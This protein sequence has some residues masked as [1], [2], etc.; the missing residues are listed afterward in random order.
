MAN[1]TSHILITFN[2][3]LYRT[4]FSLPTFSSLISHFQCIISATYIFSL[5]QTD[6]VKATWLLGY[7]NIFFLLCYSYPTIM[8]RE[9]IKLCNNTFI[10]V[11][12]HFIIVKKKKWIQH[13]H[14]FSPLIVQF[15]GFFSL[16]LT[17]LPDFNEQ[18]S[19]PHFSADCKILGKITSHFH[20]SLAGFIWSVAMC[21]NFAR[22]RFTDMGL[23]Q[24]YKDILNWNLVFVAIKIEINVW[25][26]FEY[27]IC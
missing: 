9:Y 4:F 23:V 3:L 11:F 12:A 20:S 10:F 27:W 2:G 26:Y 18:L 6:F 22:Y 8:Y 19:W 7:W 24:L 16:S 5:Y 15:N 17:R 25:R 13:E 14:L 21:A 1:Q